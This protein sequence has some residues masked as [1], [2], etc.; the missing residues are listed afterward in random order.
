MDSLCELQ[1]SLVGKYQ[2]E[3]Y[4]ILEMNVDVVVEPV[5]WLQKQEE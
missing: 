1:G 4:E 5:L 3:E 2:G